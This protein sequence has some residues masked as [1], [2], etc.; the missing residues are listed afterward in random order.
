MLTCYRK[1]TFDSLSSLF[2]C[3]FA[4]S[5]ATYVWLKVATS[6]TIY[7]THTFCIL[8]F[9]DILK[10]TLSLLLISD[11]REKEEEMDQE[12]LKENL[13]KMVLEDLL[14]LKALMQSLEILE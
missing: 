7:G 14:V 11:H 10:E 8:A 5:T 2:N 4:S 3:F 6:A 1:R 13:G 12:D 9:I